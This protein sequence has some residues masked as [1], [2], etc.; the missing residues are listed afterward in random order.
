MQPSVKLLSALASQKAA[1]TLA[2]WR[3]AVKSG[4]A[5]FK[6]SIFAACPCVSNPRG[7]IQSAAA[8]MGEISQPVAGST[9]RGIDI[10]GVTVIVVGEGDTLALALPCPRHFARS[11]ARCEKLPL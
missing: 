1:K 6:A 4:E 8:T 9:A 2:S 11:R 3:M 5:R 10:A 7:L